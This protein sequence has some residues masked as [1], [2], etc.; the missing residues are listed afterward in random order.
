VELSDAPSYQKHFNDYEVISQLHSSVPWPYPS[1]GAETFIRDFILP[2]Q[3][4]NR[5]CWGIFLKENLS[6]LIGGIELW[7]EGNPENRGFWL[8]RKFWNQGI[9]TEA[10]NLVMD[11]AFDRLGFDKLVFSNALGNDKSRRLKEKTGAR[12]VG[13]RPATFVDSSYKEAETWELTKF[14]WD[15]FKELKTLEENLWKSETRFDLSFQEK[16]FA[17]DFVE[18]GR[19]GKIYSRSEAIRTEKQEIRAKLPLPNLAFRMLDENTAQLTYISEVQYQE[20]EIANRSS[21]WTNTSEGWK[22]RFHQGTPVALR[23][24][25][26]G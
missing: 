5:W 13:I 26:N 1:N 25:S 20:L 2:R 21:I 8:G 12:L 23:N 9:M 15:T 19:S 17:L 16:V 7:R 11:C 3:G 6:E 4:N 18:F 22:L 10:V 14:E 24:V